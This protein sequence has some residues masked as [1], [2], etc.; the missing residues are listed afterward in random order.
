MK[1]DR[2]LGII[3]YLL[4]SKTASAR[5]MAEKFEV[6]VR[7]IQRDMDTLGMAGIPIYSEHGAAGGYRIIESYTLDRQ[8]INSNDIH[9][10]TTALK[11]L[12][13]AYDNRDLSKTLEKI[14]AI[15][16]GSSLPD[17]NQ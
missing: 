12:C 6:S 15:T 3:I 10:I 9:F 7:T 4:N 16:S 11:G 2:L 14:K 13:S 17:Q 1:I 8:I 5:E